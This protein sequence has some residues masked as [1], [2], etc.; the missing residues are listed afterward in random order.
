MIRLVYALRVILVALRK[1]RVR[2]VLCLLCQHPQFKMFH[3]VYDENVQT[4]TQNSKRPSNSTQGST[5]PKVHHVASFLAFNKGNLDHRYRSLGRS[6]GRSGY[7]PTQPHLSISISVLCPDIIHVQIFH[8]TYITL[9]NTLD[10]CRESIFQPIHI[11]LCLLLHA[12]TYR[13]M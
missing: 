1:H 13:K 10:A 9:N 11:R 4:N 5:S 8:I 3:M 2:Q 12:F 6:L 7:Y